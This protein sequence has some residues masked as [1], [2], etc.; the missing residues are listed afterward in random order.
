MPP[1]ASK[2]SAP[3]AMIH[4]SGTERLAFLGITNPAEKQPDSIAG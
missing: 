1:P 4:E 3:R 2:M